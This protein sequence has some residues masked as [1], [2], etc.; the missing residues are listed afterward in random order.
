MPRS[1]TPGTRR[2][3]QHILTKGA[4]GNRRI[5]SCA[6]LLVGPGSSGEES[7]TVWKLGAEGTGSVPSRP[8]S[9]EDHLVWKTKCW[10]NP[11]QI[12][13]TLLIIQGDSTFS[14]QLYEDDI[15]GAT[16]HFVKI[17]QQT[18]REELFPRKQL[19]ENQHSNINY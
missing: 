14:L 18:Q 11:C 8:R 6:S 3:E 10:F 16:K 19:I 1:G 12:L 9:N 7:V 5:N 13:S 17:I 15:T 4:A 2:L